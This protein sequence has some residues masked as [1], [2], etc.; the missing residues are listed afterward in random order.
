MAVSSRLQAENFTSFV[1]GL[2]IRR[3]DFNLAEDETPRM[4]NIDVDP[5]GGITT[6][7][8]AQRWNNTTDI[9]NPADWEP[10]S[11]ELHALSSGQFAVY[12]TSN[13][14]IWEVSQSGV[15]TDLAIPCSA[16]PHLADFAPWGNIMYFA[17]GLATR[18]A[19]R[20]G[21]G[22]TT[23]LGPVDATTAPA[24]NNDYTTP[25]G[26]V[27]P[28]AEL[29][30]AHTGYMFIAN[31]IEGGQPHPNRVRWSHPDRPEDWA[32]L[33]YIDIHEGGGYITAIIPFQDHLL[34]FKPNSV[35][36]LYG[37]DAD[38]WQLIKTSRSVG[39][40]TP[41]AVTRSETAVYF[42]SGSGRSGIYAYSGGEVVHIS[43]K[44]RTAMVE[45]VAYEETWV[46]WAGRRLYCSMPWTQPD[47]GADSRTRTLFIFDPEVGD[48]AWMAAE[49]ALGEATVVVER[50][51]LSTEH[52]LVM[53]VGVDGETP[54]LRLDGM[55]A[56]ADSIRKTLALEPF[57]ASYT[58]GWF[59]AGWPERRKS[60]RRPRLICRE[61]DETVSIRMDTFWDYKQD[62][63]RRSH[64]ITLDAEGNVFWRLNGALD[65]GG[66]DW[67]DGA[68]WG[69]AESSGSEALRP[70]P[71]GIG[72]LGVKK[73]IQLRFSTDEETPGKAWGI[74]AGVLKFVARR[75]TT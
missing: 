18:S 27:M 42:Y 38:S 60:W 47:I 48:G 71:A 14:T 70:Q 75:F 25:I 23:L 4:V 17:T 72:G 36:A 53:I 49:P 29:C 44:L 62:T 37:Y 35:W 22:L 26:G 9:G 74:D 19:K 6:R 41:G 65:P 3:N 24:W 57:V 32:E 63:P 13:A 68:M 73:A 67:G 7:R 54:I 58:T 43:E 52:P 45:I 40:A 30:A 66:F 55:A 11:A 15:P 50:A 64:I 10:R 8:G 56:A 39:A 5:R 2:N 31:T 28:F 12:L 1:G 20:E 69:A 21:L 51:D 59:N 34:I 16:T 46:C 33:D 61:P